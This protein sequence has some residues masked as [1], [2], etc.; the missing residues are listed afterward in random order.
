MLLHPDAALAVTAGPAP[1]GPE[2]RTLPGLVA[3]GKYPWGHVLPPR[4]QG[5]SL[6][7]RGGGWLCSPSIFTGSLE[8]ALYF[9][10]LSKSRSTVFRAV[11]PVVSF[12]VHA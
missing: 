1:L 8:K 10:A 2:V 11:H 5:L 6:A 3:R 12:S 7:C 4:F 9:R